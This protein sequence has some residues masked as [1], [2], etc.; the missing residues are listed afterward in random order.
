[1]YQGKFSNGK[2]APPNLEKPE[3]A[4][5][6]KWTRIA[7]IVLYSLLFVAVLV[8]F[9][10]TVSHIAG[11]AYTDAETGRSLSVTWL[12]DTPFV[13]GQSALEAIFL[14][15]L[16]AV[17]SIGLIILVFLH[18]RMKPFWAIL[19]VGVTFLAIVVT[20]VG[21]SAGTL[22]TELAGDPRE[23]VDSFFAYYV[24]G[25]YES[26]YALLSEYY[27]L[28]LEETPSDE[29]GQLEYEALKQSFSYALVGDCAV[30]QLNAIQDVE[31]TYLDLS[32]IGDEVAET[33]MA[34]IE[35][36]VETRPASQIY[37][38][39]GEYLSEVTQEAYAAAVESALAHA[40]DYYT[41]VRF[42]AE[43]VHED[44]TWLV[45]PTQSLLR[46]LTGGTAS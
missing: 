30:D 19:S 3:P 2:L 11:A 16:G 24:S 9:C 25:D 1:M 22:V 17:I 26:A 41:T 8:A 37:D 31:F 32:Q 5:K 23:T 34:N 27:T 13:L 15:G 28:G 10:V 36:I 14:A 6:P 4:K 29:I 35:Q 18:R 44:G 12:A 39:S 40:E 43:M 38:A 20:V 42:T 7:A 45:V 33:T 46:A 21:L